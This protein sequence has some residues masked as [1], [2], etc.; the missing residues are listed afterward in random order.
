MSK[1]MTSHAWL[2]RAALMGFALTLL[3][4]HMACAEP[5]GS[6]FTERA[7]VREFAREISTRNGLNEADVLVGLAQVNIQDSI[8][9]AMQRPA[10][11]K[12]WHQYRPIF[13]N[14]KRIAD[15]AVFMRE[16]AAK[17]S[18]LEQK[19]GVPAEV[20]VAIVGVETGYGRNVGKYDVLDALATLA[21]EYPPRAPFFRKELEQFFLLSREENIPL[22][23]VKGSYAGAMGM[24]QFMPSSYRQWAV[25]GDVDGKR[26]LWLSTDDVLASVA[27]YF[28]QHG[29]QRGASVTVPVQ[30]PESLL[31]SP[32]KL[33]AMLNR[34]RDLAAK[35]TLGELRA[36]GVNV[37]IS[38]GAENLPTMLMAFQYEDSI[39][40]VVGLPNF[41]VIT[42]YNHSQHYAMAVWE[43]AQAIRLRAKAAA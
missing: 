16:H 29:W 5:S 19:Y 13:L 31:D 2:R 9:Q 21:F 39:R 18:E 22:A 1:L 40:Y 25:D 7:D 41:Y 28:V 26:N 3:P 43:L 37:P 10:E 34:G 42:R 14:E 12:P 35:T 15:G 32:E 30:L 6:E 4:L 27:N 38:Q 8:I 17:L 20:L 36:L 23:S 33:D 11:S 24:P